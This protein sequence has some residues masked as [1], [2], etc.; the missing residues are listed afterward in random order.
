MSRPTVASAGEEG[1]Q[2]AHLL[3]RAGVRFTFDGDLPG[4]VTWVAASASAASDT[5]L[6]P[7]VGFIVDAVTAAPR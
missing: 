7:V 6:A 4:R 3:G 5:G 2:Q 1:S